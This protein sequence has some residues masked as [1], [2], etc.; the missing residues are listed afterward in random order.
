MSQR[1]PDNYE[2]GYGKPPK[3]TQ[4]Q[5]GHS[6]FKGR[7]RNKNKPLEDVILEELSKSVT[8]NENGK[9]SRISRTEAIIKRTIAGLLSSGDLK[10]LTR[11]LKL[12]PPERMEAVQNREANQKWLFN[13]FEEHIKAV[14]G[15]YSYRIIKTRLGMDPHDFVD[16]LLGEW[17]VDAKQLTVETQRRYADYLASPAAKRRPDYSEKC[18]FERASIAPRDMM[19]PEEPPP[20]EST[21]FPK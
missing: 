16:M 13:F 11:L 17:N 14:R 4:F 19:Y 18:G 12:V 1:N 7:K 8:I 10:G 15:Y 3:S 5:K 9:R 20:W 6:G 2:V 21:S